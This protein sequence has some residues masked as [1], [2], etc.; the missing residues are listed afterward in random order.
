VGTGAE[1]LGAR[2]EKLF[3]DFDGVRIDHPQGLVCPWLYRTDDPDPFHAVQN[4]ARLFSSPRLPDH[5]RL[6]PYAIARS[7]Q[8]A[9][10]SQV[11]RYADEWVE[12][13]SQEQVERYT[14]L[15]SVIVSTAQRHGLAPGTIAC[16]T[17]STQPYP[18]K[19]AMERYGLGRFRVTQKMN[20][21]RA[22]DVYRTDNAVEPD[23]IMMGNHD[24]RPIWARVK[25]WQEADDLYERAAYLAH[26]LKPAEQ[27]DAFA[28]ELTADT[29][30]LVHAYFAD[31]L[32][33]KAQNVIVFFAD[34]F[35]MEVT[36]NTPGTVGP[37]NWNLRVP[38]D[39]RERYA[40]NVKRL[41]ALNL[42][43]ALAL[44]LQSP[45]APAAS[46]SLLRELETTA[47]EQ[48]SARE[49]PG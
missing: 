35:G 15:L 32:V 36:Y 4:G 25:E 7:E 23:W 12:D 34:L 1:Y 10:S 46:E 41:R 40:G 11:A 18:L 31:L 6:A 8:L 14:A 27:A 13:L 2:A 30:K 39:Y 49:L 20:V 43:Y 47:G 16:E 22:S 28:R 48:I 19:R 29:G 17:L 5:P 45:L 3:T 33:S 37:D 24:T 9:D 26:R 44:A 21:S 38:R 42:A